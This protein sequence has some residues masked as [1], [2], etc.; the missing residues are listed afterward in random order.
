MYFLNY[1]NQLALALDLLLLPRHKL[2]F[3]ALK[4]LVLFRL[5]KK[6]LVYQVFFSISEKKPKAKYQKSDQVQ[7]VKL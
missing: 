4:E 6:K 7:K 5:E 3:K 2:C 1:K